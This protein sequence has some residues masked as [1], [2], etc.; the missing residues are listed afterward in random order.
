VGTTSGISVGDWVLLA[1]DGG[2]LVLQDLNGFLVDPQVGG[3]ERLGRLKTRFSSVTLKV[4][5]KHL[6]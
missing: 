4:Y 2:P 1:I 6:V 3:R 5:S